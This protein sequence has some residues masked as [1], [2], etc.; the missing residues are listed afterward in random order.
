[1]PLFGEVKREYQRQWVAR[2]RAEWFADKHCVKCGSTDEL[3][4]DHIDP[5]TKVNNSIWSWSVARR[6]VEL[7]K[8]QVLCYP[9]HKVKT[10]EQVPITQGVQLVQHGDYS[11]Y[12]KGCRCVPCKASVAPYWREYRSRKSA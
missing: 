1:M 10:R 8:C 7:E 12:K 9:C 4:L 5:K 6:V 3:Q 2:R 11:M